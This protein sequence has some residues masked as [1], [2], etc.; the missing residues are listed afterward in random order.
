MTGTPNSPKI[1][2]SRPAQRFDYSKTREAVKQQIGQGDRAMNLLLDGLKE[3]HD[4]VSE[5]EARKC[6]CSN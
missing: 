1:V 5:L 2:Q 4:R 3:L 6:S